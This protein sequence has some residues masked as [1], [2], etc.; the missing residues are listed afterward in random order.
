[1]ALMC[2][3]D[4]FEVAV[5]VVDVDGIKRLEGR[6]AEIQIRCA[7]CKVRFGFVGPEVGFSQTEPMVN[8]D[9]FELR[10]PIV[11]DAHGTMMLAG[12]M[13]GFPTDVH[14]E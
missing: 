9:R 13:C 5:N 1:V 2:E 6:Y 11:A 12:T 4:D 14:G 8:V 3:H 10:A 7:T